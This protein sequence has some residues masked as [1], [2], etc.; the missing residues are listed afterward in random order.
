MGYILLCL[1]MLVF[2]FP[3]ISHLYSFQGEEIHQNVTAGIILT[4]TSLVLQKVTKYAS[5]N[6]TC[7]AA[8]VEG[9][10]TSNSVTLAIMCK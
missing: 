6:Y 10:G 3:L 7:M 2:C 9:K 8:N 1:C 4:D 5:G